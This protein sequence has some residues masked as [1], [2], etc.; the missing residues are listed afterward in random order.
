[1]LHGGDVA[2]AKPG[3]DPRTN[4]PIITF[5]FKAAGARKFASFTRSNIGR[6]F[7]I[8][9]DG[10]VVTAPVITEPIL[11]GEGQISGTFTSDT[12]A[13]LADRLR[14]NRCAEG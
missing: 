12:A 10:D 7:A 5:R 9:V 4:Q 11:G 1:L 6:Q 13:Q 2:D 3:R 14:S 8:I